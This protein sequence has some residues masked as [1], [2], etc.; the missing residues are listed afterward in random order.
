MKRGFENYSA[1]DNREL[2]FEIAH[3][4]HYAA[5]KLGGA[6]KIIHQIHSQGG[7]NSKILA[8]DE[9][10]KG[11]SR[12]SSS[13]IKCIIALINLI[14]F[15]KNA[16]VY[17][18]HRIFLPI[19]YVIPSRCAFVCHN[20][21][22]NK[23]A[24]Y[25]FFGSARCI[26]VSEEVR[27]YLHMWNPRFRVEVIV[28][29]ISAEK[30]ED[31]KKGCTEFFDI[32]FVGRV[33]YQKGAD[34]IFDAAAELVKSE[35]LPIR[36]HMVGE[37]GLMGAELVRRAQALS[38]SS[39]FLTLHGYSASPFKVI[40]KV[41]LV[42]IPSRYEGFGLVFYEAL[43]RNHF[44]LAAKL[45]VFHAYSWDSRTVF[46]QPES[47][48]DLLVKLRDCVKLSRS[49]PPTDT[50]IKRHGIPSVATM[51]DGYVAYARNVL[52]GRG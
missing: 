23:N 29:G 39:E 20:I 31:H 46:F 13:M 37:P 41:D 35:G 24:A 47:P 17:F 12:E 45:P 52:Q 22:P 8:F 16:F 34:L 36:L 14:M 2:S 50:D 5:E 49:F 9:I 26:A 15:R 27:D 40:R 25:R 1:L 6:Q 28:N 19:A 30:D 33:D 11:S 7:P 43:E 18:H 51:I 44:V 3:V 21:F 38:L 10:W 32:G 4:F 48:A 42:C